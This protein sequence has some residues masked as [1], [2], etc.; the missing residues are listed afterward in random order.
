VIGNP[1]LIVAGIVVG[2]SG[3][4]LTQLMAKAMNRPIRN[5]IFA[6][7]ITGAAAEG[8]E[9]VEGTMKELSSPWMRRR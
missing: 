6:P 4:L 1:A 9:A 5:N 2:A 3:T 7:P 8:G